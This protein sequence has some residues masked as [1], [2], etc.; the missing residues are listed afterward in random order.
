MMLTATDGVECLVGCSGRT[1][2]RDQ[3]TDDCANGKH[4]RDTQRIELNL[5]V[6]MACRELAQAENDNLLD[7]KS[8]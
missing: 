4:S 7:K 5:S 3:T 2:H 6:N 8:H 1:G